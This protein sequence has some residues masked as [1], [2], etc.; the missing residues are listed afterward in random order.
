MST[1]SRVDAET[2]VRLGLPSVIVRRLRSG[3]AAERVGER[4]TDDDPTDDESK[5]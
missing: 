5:A 1:T 2:L 4:R 3:F